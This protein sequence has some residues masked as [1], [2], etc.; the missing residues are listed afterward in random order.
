M[1]LVHGSKSAKAKPERK[2][3]MGNSE[4][5]FTAAI[6]V[7]TADKLEERT[8][9]S[10]FWVDLTNVEDEEDLTEICYSLHDDEDDPCIIVNNWDGIP[11]NLIQDNGW[12]DSRIWEWLKLPKIQ[13]E[14]VASHW[15]S[16]PDAS[17][18]DALKAV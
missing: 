12:P 10:E 14:G 4:D 2:T 9:D 13:R 1:T 16:H 3:E 17:V 8:F 11:T 18:Q 5:I 6:Y 7:T 15:K